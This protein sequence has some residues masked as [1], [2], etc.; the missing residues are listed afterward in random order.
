MFMVIFLIIDYIY[1]LATGPVADAVFL[2][3]AIGS[4]LMQMLSI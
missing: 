1:F 2:I 4:F 3:D